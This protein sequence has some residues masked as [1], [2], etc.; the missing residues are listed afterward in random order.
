MKTYLYVSPSVSTLQIDLETDGNITLAPEVAAIKDV[1]TNRIGNTLVVLIFR[2]NVSEFSGFFGIVDAE[3]RSIGGVVGSTADASDAHA[4][5][6]KLSQIS[7]DQIQLS[8]I[9]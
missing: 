3:V 5:V 8:V 6:T 2:L 9:G 4:V 7:V 1:Q